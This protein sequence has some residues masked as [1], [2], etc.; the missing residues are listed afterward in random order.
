MDLYEYVNTS[1]ISIMHFRN[2]HKSKKNWKV[3][4]TKD[5]PRHVVKRARNARRYTFVNFVH[6]ISQCHEHLKGLIVILF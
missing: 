5:A 1:R 2:A 6:K 3:S 4:R